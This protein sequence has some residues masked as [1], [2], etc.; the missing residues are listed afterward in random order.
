MNFLEDS[1]S[2][3]PFSL[4]TCGNA[5]VVN[6]ASGF[7]KREASVCLERTSIRAGLFCQTPDAVFALRRFGK[8][9]EPEGGMILT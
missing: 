2:Q 5:S 8:R 4:K 7:L 1:C 3:T 9:R 6:R